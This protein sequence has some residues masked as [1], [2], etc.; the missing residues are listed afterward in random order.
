MRHKKVG[1]RKCRPSY[2]VHIAAESCI[3]PW[4]KLSKSCHPLH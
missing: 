1:H 3:T 4:K 2:E